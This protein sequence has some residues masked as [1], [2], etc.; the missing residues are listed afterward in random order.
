MSINRRMDKEDLIHI[1][2]RIILSH[3]KGWNNPICSNTDGPGEYHT[4]WI[5]SDRERQISY[6]LYAE[7]NQNDKKRTYL[8]NRDS[9]ISKSNLWLSKGKHGERDKL[10]AWG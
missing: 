4:M 10:G 7:S 8:Q 5:K 1:Y 3:K 9:Q 6:H 2:Y